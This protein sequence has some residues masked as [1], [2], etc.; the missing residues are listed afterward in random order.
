[1]SEDSLISSDQDHDT[2]RGSR[3]VSECSS[4]YLEGCK[5][6]HTEL[7]VSNLC[8]RDACAEVLTGDALITVLATDGLLSL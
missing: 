4:R 5:E 2:A 8:A 3:H 1:M 6:K 7:D